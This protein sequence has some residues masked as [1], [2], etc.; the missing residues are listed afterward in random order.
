MF[1]FQTVQCFQFHDN[2]IVAYKISP[3]SLIKQNTLIPISKN[4]FPF[5]RYATH[6]KLNFQ[7]IL[8]QWF[9][10]TRPDNIMHFHR[11]AYDIV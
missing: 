9:S 4:L 2:A 7:S 1:V 5:V 10:E 8:I 3:K 6:F 11:C